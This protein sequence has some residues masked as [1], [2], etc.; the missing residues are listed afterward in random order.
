M[1][2]ENVLTFDPQNHSEGRSLPPDHPGSGS[3]Q[4]LFQSFTP[5]HTLRRE[6]SCV[7]MVTAAQGA[8]PQRAVSVRSE[9]EISARLPQELQN[10]S[11]HQ[12]CT[13][14]HRTL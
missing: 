11:D 6:S 2:T 8:F 13:W 5:E 14:I 3:K 9:S 10:R 4:T 12:A 1:I 7:A